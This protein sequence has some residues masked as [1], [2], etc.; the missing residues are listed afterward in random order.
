MNIAK[1]AMNALAPK[2]KAFEKATNDPAS[3][4]K[5]ALLEYLSRN[6]HTEYGKKYDFSSIKSVKDYQERVPIIDCN[7][8]RRYTERMINGEQNI[9]T[10]D[11]VSYFGSTSGTTG[12]PKYIPVTAYSRAK[13][14]EVMKL[15]SYYIYKDY[16]SILDGKIFAIIDPEIKGYTP[17]GIPFG[18][19]NGHA[20]VNLPEPI[21]RYYAI[22]Y[23]IFSIQDYDSRYYSMLRIALEQNVT[24]L[25]T[26]NPSCI[27]LL[28]QKID[29]W[30]DRIIRD[31]ENGT[32]EKGW[33][34]PEDVRKVIEKNLKPNKKR[35]DELRAILKKKGKLIPKDFWPNMKL[36]ESWKGGTVKLYLKEL[37]KYFGNIPIRDFGCL[38]TEMR[39]SIPMNDNGAGGVLAILT[40]FYEFIPKEDMGKKQKRVLLCDEL[41]EG[42]EYIIIVTTPGGLY[43]YDIDDIIKVDG[44]YNKTPIIEFVQKGLNAISITGEKVYASQ[45]HDAVNKS[46]DKVNLLIKFF[47]ASIQLDKPPRYI[48]LVEFDGDP[49]LKTK[50]DFLKSVDMELGHANLE[51]EDTRR[52]MELGAPILKEVKKGEFEKYRTRRVKEGSH[53]TQFKAPELTKDTDF[54]KNFVIKEEILIERESG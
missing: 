22:P 9:L 16:P 25:A 30:E 26:L 47:S 37:P 48:F 49:S 4:Q 2:A 43:R 50:K 32:L 5:A 11:K 51:Y 20:Y 36:I 38:S 29:I 17:C 19:E 41:E 31:I 52:R 21:K 54:Q 39:S 24:T 53:E 42:R 34:I 3:Y 44:F 18:P 46:L 40:N 23:T 12:K 14:A 1:I 45:V 28:C 33:N 13:K 7:D 15:W 6:R 27:I 35:A 10:A 8:L